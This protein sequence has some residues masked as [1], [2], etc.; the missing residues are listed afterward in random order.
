MA[1]RYMLDED[2]PNNAVL[3]HYGIWDSC[4]E[5][6]AEIDGDEAWGMTRAEAD[7]ALERLRSAFPKERS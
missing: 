6:Y 4:R 5:D 1:E 7:E 2:A 3:R